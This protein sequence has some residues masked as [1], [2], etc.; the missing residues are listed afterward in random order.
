VFAAGRAGAAEHL[1]F[2]RFQPV[3]DALGGAGV[4]GQAQPGGDSAAR[5]VRR[6]L[7]GLGSPSPSG[8]TR[9]AT[10]SSPQPSMLASPCGMYKKPPRTPIR[11]PRSGTTVPAAASTGMPPI[12]SPPTS[13]APPDNNRLPV[14]ASAWPGSTDSGGGPHS[15][16]GRVLRHLTGG[17]RNRACANRRSARQLACVRAIPGARR[18]GRSG[19]AHAEHTVAAC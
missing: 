15:S 17:Q 4:V 18:T 9:S 13:P 11:G 12:S 2:D 8:R 14:A 1:S 6:P 16:D 19:A 7:P 3:G 5:I 10:H